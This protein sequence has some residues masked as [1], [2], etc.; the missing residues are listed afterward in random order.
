MRNLTGMSEVTVDGKG[1]FLMPSILRKQLQD[2]QQVSF[3]IKRSIYHQCLELIPME[4]WDKEMAVLGKLNRFV[5]KN[6]DFIRLYLAG[7]RTLELDDAGRVQIPK[8]LIVFSEITRD[9]V[10]TSSIN[11]LEIWDKSKYEAFITDGI[12][13]FGDLA[14]EVMGQFPNEPFE[15]LT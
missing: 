8:D 14:Q 5:K 12:Q 1:R 9:A 11:R 13:R 3:V 6:A 4:E 15:P 2:A 10:V 7:V